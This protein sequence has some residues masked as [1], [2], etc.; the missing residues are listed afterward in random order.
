MLLHNFV[1]KLE[2][3]SDSYN[4][5]AI[6]LFYSVSMIL[7]GNYTKVIWSDHFFILDVFPLNEFSSKIFVYLFEE[8]MDDQT[9]IIK[10]MF[11]IVVKTAIT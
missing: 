10:I 4:D 7:G 5:F 8:S 1:Y 11:N 6:M 2:C 3:S 9:T